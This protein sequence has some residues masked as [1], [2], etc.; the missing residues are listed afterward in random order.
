[1]FQKLEE[2]D[3]RS[4]HQLD[5]LEREQRH[6]Q[7]QLAQL[8]TLGERDRVRTDSLDSHLDSERSESDRGQ[9][10]VHI[11]FPVVDFALLRCQDLYLLPPCS[12]RL[13]RGDRSRRGKH[14]VLPW[15][16]GQCEHQWRER[17]GRPQQPAELSQRWGLLHLQSKTGLLCL[18]HQPILLLQLQ[19]LWL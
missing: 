14:R 10:N 13:N 4:Q 12:L 6:L 16:N 5:T 11:F 2:M 19:S 17:P 3:R 1:M 9:I 18:T 7:R 15:R 8:Q